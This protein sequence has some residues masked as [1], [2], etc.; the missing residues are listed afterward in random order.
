MKKILICLMTVAIIFLCGCVQ[1]IEYETKY[2]DN[3]TS[4][5]LRKAPYNEATVIENL[6]YGE[7]VSFEKDVENG[8]AKVA[9]EGVSGYV[10]SAK[11]SGE[12]PGR[13]IVT[14]P[15]ND[16]EETKTSKNDYARLISDFSGNHIEEYISGYVRPLYNSIN[17]NLSKYSKKNY[18]GATYW[19]DGG[20]LCKKELVQGS[21][22]YNM[23]RQYYYDADTGEMVFAFVFK[24][25]QEHR[26]YF[27]DGKLVRYI[28]DDGKIIDNPTSEKCLEM[29]SYVLYE[30]YSN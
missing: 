12:K 26:L 7:D 10:L 24:N 23:S 14:I 28:G 4:T 3:C 30:A 6:H 13:K 17:S 9:H 29:A 27:E 1:K 15:P 25:T 20:T 16:K 22:G 21:N 5:E 11:L 18:S 8:Y 2:I 19:Y